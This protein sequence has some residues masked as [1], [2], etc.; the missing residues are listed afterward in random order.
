MIRSVVGMVNGSLY[1]LINLTS[2]S[3]RRPVP[4]NSPLQ[5]GLGIGSIQGEMLYRAAADALTN[6]VLHDE[7]GTT[8]SDPQYGAVD[9]ADCRCAMGDEPRGPA[10][11]PAIKGHL[12]LTDVQGAVGRWGSA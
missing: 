3:S 12:L 11:R 8:Q 5:L 4:V 10:V 2:R 7:H 9:G 1:N 6:S